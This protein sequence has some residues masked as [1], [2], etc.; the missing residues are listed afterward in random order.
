MGPRNIDDVPALFDFCIDNGVRFSISPELDERGMP[1]P[2]LSRA[3]TFDRYR[4][5]MEGLIQNKRSRNSL[6]DLGAFLEHLTEFRPVRCH[7]S[8]APRVYAD[9]SFIHPCP[10]RCRQP[11][12]VRGAGSWKALIVEASRL[13]DDLRG[14]TSPCFLPCYVETSLLVR[15][16]FALLRNLGG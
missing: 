2:E 10:N 14:C 9:G 16:P 11:L 3:G 6:M 4:R 12:D 5:M 7:P 15:K 13:N 8:I 1:V